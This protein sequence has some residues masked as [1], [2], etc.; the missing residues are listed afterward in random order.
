VVSDPAVEE[1][2]HNVGVFDRA[3]G[4]E[5]WIDAESG[6]VLVGERDPRVPR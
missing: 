3:L 4:D 2:G 6:A 5:V 1:R